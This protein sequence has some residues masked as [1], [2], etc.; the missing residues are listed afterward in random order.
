MSEIKYRFEYVK[1]QVDSLDYIR[2]NLRL[3]KIGQVYRGLCPFHGE[4][5]PSLTV[6]PPGTMRRGESQEHTSFYCFGCGAAGDMFEFRKR[7]EKLKSSVDALQ[8]FEEELGIIVDEEST[9]MNYLLEALNKAK[10]VQE[11]TLNISEINMVCS[12]M[13][14]NYLLWVKDNYPEQY[15]EEVEVIEKYYKYF[16]FAF[17]EKSAFECMQLIDDVQSKI[18][19]RRSDLLNS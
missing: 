1:T 13:S 5:T 11:N 6:Y 19:K 7:I 9:K 4:K 17:E 16:D 10:N 12:S 2:N 14:R 8:K 15:N 3:K 18:E